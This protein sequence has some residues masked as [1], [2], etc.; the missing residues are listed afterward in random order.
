MNA[1]F[2]RFGWGVLFTLIDFRFGFFDVLPDIVGY[3]LMWSAVRNLGHWRN[4]YLKMEP[5][6]AILMLLSLAEIFP[7]WGVPGGPATASIPLLV[8]SGIMLFLTMIF[9]NHFMYTVSRHAAEASAKEFAAT[10]NA[11]RKFFVLI[12]AVWLLAL[13]FSLNW[14]ESIVEWTFVM[15][16]LYI[17]AQLLLF[18]SCRG[19][20]KL[21]A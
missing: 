14:T 19:A 9:I 4:V 11:R 13:P 7:V 3:G 5:I 2:V 20:A 18:F 8:Y 10:V 12:S 1:A 17:I 21:I 15:G 16:I 6:A